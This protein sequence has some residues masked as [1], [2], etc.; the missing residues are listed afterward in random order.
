MAWRALQAGLEWASGE[1]AGEDTVVQESAEDKTGSWEAALTLRSWLNR[2]PARACQC[3]PLAS[4]PLGFGQQPCKRLL[5]PQSGLVC[6][7]CAENWQKL[8]FN[9]TQQLFCRRVL[10][11][12]P[13]QL[14]PLLGQGGEGPAVAAGQE[15]RVHG[16]TCFCTS[17]CL[18]L[19]MGMSP[20][21]CWCK[22]QCVVL[23]QVSPVHL[24]L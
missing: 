1:E 2:L 8:A 22:L 6:V 14:A 20:A 23:L 17:M 4:G 10:A 3:S 11:G 15:V 7:L 12:G 18:P 21:L 24:P 9:S 13:A 5:M 19:D 16:I